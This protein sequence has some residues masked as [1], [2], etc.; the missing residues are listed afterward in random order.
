MLGI[1]VDGSIVGRGR[2]RVGDAEITEDGFEAGGDVLKWRHYLFPW[3]RGLSFFLSAVRIC[4][5]SFSVHVVGEVIAFE[6]FPGE[7]GV[8]DCQ[9]GGPDLVRVDP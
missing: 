1:C 6:K 4:A 9:W 2:G 7:F 5:I 3:L 8:G